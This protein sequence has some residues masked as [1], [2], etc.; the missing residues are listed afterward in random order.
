MVI[1]RWCGAERRIGGRNTRKEDANIRQGGP[2]QEPRGCAGI[3]LMARMRMSMTDR[4][5]GRGGNPRDK[6]SVIE[7]RGGQ[8]EPWPPRHSD[9]AVDTVTL[10]SSFGSCHRPGAVFV[11]TSVLTDGVIPCVPRRRRRPPTT[12]C[13]LNEF[14]SGV[15][16]LIMSYMYRDTSEINPSLTC[17]SSP[18]TP[19]RS[20]PLA[21]RTV[22]VS[23]SVP[24]EYLFV[25]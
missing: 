22:L 4:I 15:V 9:V 24:F 2:F 11:M 12:R 18:S 3:S 13:V 20:Y 14:S 23:F 25:S 5:G 19:Q 21:A 10:V 1:W 6:A 16:N 7:N 17:P 8:S